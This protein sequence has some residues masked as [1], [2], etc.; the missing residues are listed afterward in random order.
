MDFRKLSVLISLGLVGVAHADP[1]GSVNQSILSGVQDTSNL[2]IG[3]ATTGYD[4]S[5][6]TQPGDPDFYLNA[7]DVVGGP[8]WDPSITFNSVG[9]TIGSGSN[10][11]MLGTPLQADHSYFW[12]DLI[13]HDGAFDSAI[14]PGLYSFDVVFSGGSTPTSAD[15]LYT[16]SLQVEIVERI[17]AEVTVSQDLAVINTGETVTVSAIL[18]NNMASRDFVTT[19][20]F[21]SGTTP[22]LGLNFVGD[23][24][25]KTIAPGGSRYDLHSTWTA[26]ATDAPGDY[27]KV[28]GVVGGLY[29][30]DNFL[31]ATTS[32]D[33]VHISVVPEPGTMAALGL[34]ALAVL[35]RRKK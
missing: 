24:F 25:N 3:W 10:E 14:A 20:W 29:N 21:V 4:F 12:E 17:D 23:W 5:F 27:H 18:Q 6:S 22:G 34:G 33:N 32:G 8:G 13:R 9:S 35:R 1:S 2:W 7:I 30:G 19:T 28:G 15:I 26:L 16:Q 31:F 11:Y